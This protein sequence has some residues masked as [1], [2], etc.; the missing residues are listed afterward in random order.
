MSNK[1]IAETGFQ[2]CRKVRVHPDDLDSQRWEMSEMLPRHE[3]SQ[4]SYRKAS[5]HINARTPNANRCC[6]M[7][8]HFKV[9]L[10]LWRSTSSD[11]GATLLL[12][13]QQLLDLFGACVATTFE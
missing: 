11:L 9:R 4:N 1:Y 13:R 5:F 6:A 10:T 8:S 7:Q 3:N 12:E 2:T